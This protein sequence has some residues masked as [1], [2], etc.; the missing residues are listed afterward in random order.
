MRVSKLAILFTSVFFLGALSL[1][2]PLQRTAR[3]TSPPGVVDIF[4]NNAA[5]SYVDMFNT[6]T[7]LVPNVGV[8]KSV[9]VNGRVTDGDGVGT[10]F[11]DGDL[12]YVELRF[13]RA[14]VGA[15]CESDVNNCYKT[16]CTVTPN[17][18]TVLNY[19]CPIE[20]SFL[21]DSTMPGGAYESD[22]WNA[23]VIVEDDTDQLASSIKTLEIDTILALNIPTSINFGELT[24]AQSTTSLNNV[25]FLM[26]QEG[27]GVA[28][29]TVSGTDMTCSVN[30]AITV[31]NIEWSLID[32]GADSESSIPLTTSP[33]DVNLQIG[34]D[35]D[36][37]YS[38]S[39]YWN[40]TTPDVVNGVC[41]GQLSV[42]AI[43]V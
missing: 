42:E 25:E 7:P 4:V 8:V 6:V 13:Y 12:D 37:G 30:G 22:V 40:V 41:T 19:S 15:G 34:T 11:P 18:G 29:V 20:I 14:N 17:S 24:R 26:T 39:L 9:Y 27:N 10:G 2:A 31:D 5:Y 3:A 33:V 21:I 35:D 36:V 38:D 1:C 23:E 43:A 32:V 16:Y 28:S